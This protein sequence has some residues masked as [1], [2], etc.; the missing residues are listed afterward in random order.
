MFDPETLLLFDI[1]GTLLGGMPPAH[2]QAICEAV[3]QVFD[4]P[5]QSSR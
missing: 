2:R 4:V 3:R 1:D 5:S